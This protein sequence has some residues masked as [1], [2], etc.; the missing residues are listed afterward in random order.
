MNE[1]DLY[2]P[3][4]EYFEAQG[5]EVQAEVKHCD[6]VACS[7]DGDMI[8]VE[9][10]T[11]VNLPLLVQATAR[12]A[13]TEN[14]YIAI[15]KKSYRRKQW[16]G[17][18]RVVKQLGLGLLVVTISPLTTHVKEHFA[19]TPM[20]KTVKRKRLAVDKEVRE[21]ISSYNVG[22]STGSELMTAYKQNAII[23]ARFLDQ[24]GESSAANLRSYGT[25][26][27]TRSILADNHYGWF[28]RVKRGVYALESG[29]D[30]IETK[31]PELWQTASNIVAEQLRE[32]G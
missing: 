7:P 12:Q 26:D 1:T 30:A 6:L 25:P 31:F 11:G 18:Q 9:L 2:A 23:I 4:K 15:P 10:K 3:I 32:K 14:V 19:P 28:K 22:G 16:L 13:I 17:I 21:R 20:R 29:S 5:L 24:L 8:V 27:N